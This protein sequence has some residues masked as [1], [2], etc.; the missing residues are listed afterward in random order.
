MVR[1]RALASCYVIPKHNNHD[2]KV[3]LAGIPL[4][5]YL[6]GWLS[7]AVILDSPLLLN[8]CAPLLHLHGAGATT[9]TPVEKSPISRTSVKGG[10][11]L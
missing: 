10:E 3:G 7:L 5:G 9:P 4:L 8:H 2:K 11:P 6:L 1:L